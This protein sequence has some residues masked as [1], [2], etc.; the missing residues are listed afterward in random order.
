MPSAPIAPAPKPPLKKPAA[1]RKGTKVAAGAGADTSLD[2]AD[3]AASAAA[4]ATKLKWEPQVLGF[5]NAKHTSQTASVCLL[6]LAVV[7]S[8][9]PRFSRDVIQKFFALGQPWIPGPVLPEAVARCVGIPQYFAA[10]VV[11]LPFL[12]LIGQN[13]LHVRW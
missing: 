7:D 5:S 1:A 6:L 4:E 10:C 11:S 13:S 3:G 2:S 12:P 8:D 9:F